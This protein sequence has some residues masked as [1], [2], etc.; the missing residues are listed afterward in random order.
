MKTTITVLAAGLA[1]VTGYFGA[2]Y[3]TRKDLGFTPAKRHVRSLA[4]NLLH[5]EVAAAREAGIAPEATTEQA[6]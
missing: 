4:Q 5:T 2:R 1:I 6:V 3:F